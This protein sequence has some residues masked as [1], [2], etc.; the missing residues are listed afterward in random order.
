MWL[1]PNLVTGY[2]CLSILCVVIYKQI[3]SAVKKIWN[4]ECGDVSQKN[5]L[6]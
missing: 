1:Q 4:K 2:P 5:A 3:D 6:G